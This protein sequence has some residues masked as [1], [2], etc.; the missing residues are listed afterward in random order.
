MWSFHR[1]SG[2][3]KQSPRI[4]AEERSR[5]PTNLLLEPQVLCSPEATDASTAAQP[6]ALPSTKRPISKATFF[7]A[8][9]TTKAL[10]R[11]PSWT[12]SETQTSIPAALWEADF[13]S[14]HRLLT[15]RFGL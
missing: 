5:Q 9:K 15:T 1:P 2:S 8:D 7:T 3:E 13:R 4:L 10:T 12:R 6:S 14:E 11:R